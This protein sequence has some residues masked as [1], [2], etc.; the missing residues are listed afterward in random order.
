VD[1]YACTKGAPIG[2]GRTAEI[3]TWGNQQILKLLIPGF[4]L[5]PIHKERQ[6][7]RAVYEAG[8]PA[9]AVGELVEL[10]DRLGIVYERIDG[11]TMLHVV[12]EKPW[13]LARMARQLAETQVTIHSHTCADLPSQRE[14]F[15]RE[16]EQAPRLSAQT[17]KQ[18][19]QA[20]ER[21][22]DGNMICHG[23]FHPDNVL[24]AARGPVVIDW[25]NTGR[26]NPLA[27]VARTALTLGL[28]SLPPGTSLFRGWFIQSFRR[29]F[30]AFYLRRYFQLWPFA[31]A[32]MRAWL[33][34]VAAARLF[35]GIPGEADQL[36]RLIEAALRE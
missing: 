19:L 15:K 20:L 34:P 31:Q 3:F 32:Q 21:L 16:I 22:P 30:R 23:D 24:M 7:S 17:K 10:E 26:G 12:L 27:D 25:M 11:P 18:V 36:V 14:R 5:D 4:P 9:P 6:A 33:L 13:M 35:E 1:S 29:I 8:L 2:Q 28:G